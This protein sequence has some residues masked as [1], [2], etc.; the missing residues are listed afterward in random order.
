MSKF[1]IAKVYSGHASADIANFK[2]FLFFFVLH[3]PL[4][5]F[6]IFLHEIIHHL[7]LLNKT[8]FVARTDG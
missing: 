8:Q 2:F 1:Y 3:F 4:Y 6:I 7:T 5:I